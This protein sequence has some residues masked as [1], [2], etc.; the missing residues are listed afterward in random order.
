MANINV[1][2]FIDFAI[3]LTMLMAAN[4]FTG[5]MKA[6]KSKTFE[7]STLFDGCFNYILWL[8]G[9]CLTVVGFQVYGGELEVTISDKTYTLL[10][11]IEL[12]KKTV[13]VYWGAKAV[14]NVFE[15]GKIEKVVEANDPQDKFNADISVEDN[16]VG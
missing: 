10:Q 15:Y 2:D 6:R 14:Q 9:T 8:V 5:A 7:W 3:A 13:Y 1:N 4:A 12:A 11:A 16:A